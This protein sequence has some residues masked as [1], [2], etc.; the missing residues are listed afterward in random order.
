GTD[1]AVLGAG[2]AA[3]GKVVRRDVTAADNAGLGRP[4]VPEHQVDLLYPPGPNAAVVRDAGVEVE[5]TEQKFVT[6]HDLLAAD[7]QAEVLAPEL[8]ERDIALVEL[9][10]RTVAKDGASQAAAPE[11]VAGRA[12]HAG[13]VRG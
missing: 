10:T 9:D 3:E 13:H 6:C 7:P 4:G 8:V 2:R 5:V 1:A 11:A 12:G